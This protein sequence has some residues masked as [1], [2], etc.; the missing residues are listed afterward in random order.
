MMCFGLLPLF[1]LLFAL[2]AMYWTNRCN[3]GGL[4]M[5]GSYRTQLLRHVSVAG[6]A[7]QP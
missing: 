6:P 3:T 1:C 2:K 7:G 5:G 4:Y